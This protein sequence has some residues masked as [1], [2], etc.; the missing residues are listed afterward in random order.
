MYIKGGRVRS[1]ESGRLVRAKKKKVNENKFQ[2][3]AKQSNNQL[4]PPVPDF[5]QVVTSSC[6]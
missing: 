1:I 5:Q 4:L 6:N 3:D 2:V